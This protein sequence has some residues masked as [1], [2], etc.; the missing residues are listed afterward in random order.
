VTTTEDKG[1]RHNDQGNNLEEQRGPTGLSLV[2]RGIP[3]P[4][5]GAQSEWMVRFRGGDMAGR[6]W[7]QSHSGKAWGVYDFGGLPKIEP[8]GVGSEWVLLCVEP[9]RG[10]GP[11]L[12]RVYGIMGGRWK[13]RDG[14]RECGVMGGCVLEVQWPKDSRCTIGDGT[15]VGDSVV[16]KG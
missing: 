8:V 2:M 9:S 11:W 7:T 10:R 1:D 3:L 6:S 12:S 14:R 16:R 4:Q 13:E 5:L 15:S